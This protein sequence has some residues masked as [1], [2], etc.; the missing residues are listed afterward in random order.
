MKSVPQILAM[1]LT[2]NIAI[3]GLAFI[4]GLIEICSWGAVI[5]STGGLV[6]ATRKL[7]LKVMFKVVTVFAFAGFGGYTVLLVVLACTKNL[8]L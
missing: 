8:E 4:F 3:V 1:F 7:D 2:L 5:W 6:A